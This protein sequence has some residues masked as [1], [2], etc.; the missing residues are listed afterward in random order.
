[1]P[2]GEKDIKG[3]WLKRE[4]DRERREPAGTSKFHPRTGLK[5]TEGSRGIGVLFL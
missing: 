4:V 2:G 5:G 1:M 3:E